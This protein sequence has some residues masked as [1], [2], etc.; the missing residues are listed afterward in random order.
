MSIVL[1]RG[2]RLAVAL[3]TAAITA[4]LRPGEAAAGRFEDALTLIRSGDIARIEQ[5]FVTEY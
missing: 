2:V 4:F 3:V 5:T 1:S